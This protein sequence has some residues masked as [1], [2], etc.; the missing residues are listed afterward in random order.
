M[1]EDN[2]VGFIQWII[3]EN[4]RGYVGLA[5][6]VSDTNKWI[7]AVIEYPGNIR[8][9][10]S[11]LIE[12]E[13]T[14]DLYFCPTIIDEERRIKEN[15]TRSHVLWS[16]LDTCDPSNLEVEPTIVTETSPGR[17][18]GFW[19]LTSQ[20]HADTAELVNKK[21]ALYHAQHGAD[22]SGWDLTQLLRVPGTKNF[23]YEE[24]PI[25]K[26]DS[27]NSELI[28]DID[29]VDEKYTFE[30]IE[31]QNVEIDNSP[32][33][34]IL[35]S[36]SP[37]EIIRGLKNPNPRIWTLFEE[38]PI[39]DRSAK[40]W[41]LLLTLFENGATKEETF[42]VASNAACNKFD[43]PHHLWRDVLRAQAKVK[44][45][46][47]KEGIFTGEGEVFIPERSILTETEISM[48]MDYKTIIDDY[49]DW[50]SKATDAAPQY[51]A[52]VCMVT[53][54][55]LLAG[56]LRLYTQFG[57]IKP[58]IWLM[59]MG[60]TTT[61]RK[62]T[63]MEMGTDIIDEVYP[64]ALLA[65]D[66]T[67]EG[68]VTSISTRPGRVSL[69]HRDEISGLIDA[70]AKKDY[71]AGMLEAFTKLYD[72]K[73]MKRI[74]RKE[75]IDV[76]DPVFIMLTGGTK[77]G[78]MSSMSHHHI[79]SGFA[80]RFCYISAKSDPS[81]RRGLGPKT[82]VSMA[83]RKL[84]VSRFEEIFEKFNTVN[85]SS[86]FDPSPTIE[87]TLTEEA[88]ILFNQYDSFLMRIAENSSIGVTEHLTPMLARLSMT[89]LKISML[90]A[91]SKLDEDKVEV[92]VKDLVKAF[93]YINLWKDYS[94]E[95]VLN[96]GRTDQERLIGDAYKLITDSG[97]SGISRPNI[98]Q[99]LKLTSRNAELVFS[100]LEQRGLIFSKK[101][102]NRFMY[103]SVRS[104]GM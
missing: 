20:V 98:M 4:E 11:F 60:D 44:R 40:L 35:N 93:Y 42:I 57:E 29:V 61:S 96:A 99:A 94:I 62:S 58:N 88:W 91:A 32:I 47:V 73:R 76:R 71:N 55:C 3:G 16:D 37:E 48:A 45:D 85:R 79:R 67:I 33:P 26:I 13:L 1:S 14:S 56:T 74:L 46:R 25:V 77:E 15:I 8:G 6:R 9:I 5:A 92:T 22:P 75:Q 39:E 65:T 54:S 10:E 38:T 66:G 31:I 101:I 72:G 95:V 68:L 2:R 21:I 43:N 84:L 41:E 50:A 100:T 82:H 81:R 80:P 36:D 70:M 23:K 17:Y 30:D 52:G 18:Q 24:L 64:D 59:I 86:L 27:F 28:Y 34:K 51:H 90:I 97:E 89:G 78:I 12:N 103:F 104:R 53:L 102:T 69:F 87:V 49:C 7:E 19:K 83:A 63:S